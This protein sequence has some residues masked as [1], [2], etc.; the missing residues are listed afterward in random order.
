AEGVQSY[1]R[2]NGFRD[3]PDGIHGPINTPEKLLVYDP[4]LYKLVQ[5]MFACGNTFIKRCNSTREAE[6]SQV[7]K[8]NCDR[9]RQ[10]Q[11]KIHELAALSGQPCKDKSNFCTG[12]AL[13]GSALT[14]LVIWRTIA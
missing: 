6:N 12:W 2:V 5:L 9:T 10:Y 8:M 13:Q 7:L 1:F 4:S 3:P 14:I 11:M